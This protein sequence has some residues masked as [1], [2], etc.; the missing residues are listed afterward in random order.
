MTCFSNNYTV[1]GYYLFQINKTGMK[2]IVPYHSRISNRMRITV[3]GVEK[4]FSG[5]AEKHEN[6][7]VR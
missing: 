1:N 4:I 6:F 7:S 5:T 2:F 3:V